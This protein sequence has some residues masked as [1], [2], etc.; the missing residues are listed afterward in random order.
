M[1]NVYAIQ[2]QWMA[3]KVAVVKLLPALLPD[4]TV[5]GRPSQTRTA[6]GYQFEIPF[7]DVDESQTKLT[8][9]SFVMKS[10]GHEWA[11][12]VL[13]GGPKQD[14]KDME[15]MSGH[16]G[17]VAAGMFGDAL[18]SDYVLRERIYGATPSR[19][20]P[21]MSDRVAAGE[22]MILVIKGVMLPSEAQSGFYEVSSATLKG[23]QFGNPAVAKQL[24]IELFDDQ[25]SV[26]FMIGQQAENGKMPLTQA[27]INR[28]I[29]S[30]RRDSAKTK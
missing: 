1:G 6:L 16:H 30:V 12:G 21:F 29:Q 3:R 20:S 9:H 24:N 27:Q 13:A 2:A 8:D 4:S 22:Y 11:F 17:R 18:Q 28:L 19:V 15:S 7:A 14:V 10:H 25:G 5:D 26:S 23:F